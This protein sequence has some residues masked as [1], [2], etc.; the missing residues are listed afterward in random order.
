MAGGS[1]V[2]GL[3][4]GLSNGIRCGVKNAPI[5][6]LNSIQAQVLLPLLLAIGRLLF[7]N[8]N[9]EIP[10]FIHKA[11]S[12]ISKELEKRLQKLKNRYEKLIDTSDDKEEIKKCKKGSRFS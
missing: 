5:D 6:E 12:K 9:E 1:I 3:G 11:I 7:E 10:K 4:F 2:L 8:G